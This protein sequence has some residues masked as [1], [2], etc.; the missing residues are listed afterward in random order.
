MQ[1]WQREIT[2]SFS[3][4]LSIFFFFFYRSIKF[5]H[6][7]ANA[8]SWRVSTSNVT[9]NNAVRISANLQDKLHNIEWF[10]V[11]LC[12]HGC[13]YFM[14]RTNICVETFFVQI[15]HCGMR[16]DP[17]QIG[18]VLFHSHHKHTLKWLRKQSSNSSVVESCVR[19]RLTFKSASLN[20]IERYWTF[21]GNKNSSKIRVDPKKCNFLQGKNK[22]NRESQSKRN[23][24]CW[25][26]RTG[27]GTVSPFFPNPRVSFN[28]C[29]PKAWINAE[30]WFQ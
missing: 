24:I 25:N 27:D 8:P 17:K 16:P 10:F 11:Y 5:V 22:K 7:F 4:S 30:R 2:P 23:R 1:L 21:K 15:Y 13:K 29:A 9:F 28:S 14:M 19:I 18:K 6:S 20:K 26:N 3:F 12:L